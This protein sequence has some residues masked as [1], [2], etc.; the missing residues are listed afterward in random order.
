MKCSAEAKIFCF[1]DAQFLCLLWCTQT[2]QNSKPIH[3]VVLGPR[4]LPWFWL[5]EWLSRDQVS[6]GEQLGGRH[7]SAA[8]AQRSLQY[9][10]LLLTEITDTKN[11]M[12][13]VACTLDIL[14][15]YY[16]ECRT[17]SENDRATVYFCCF[18]SLL[19]FHQSFQSLV[20]YN[21]CDRSWRVGHD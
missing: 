2:Q 20:C 10:A 7:F 12:M 17:G 15:F 8:S 21:S 4:W 5:L 1:Y 11:Q 6:S 18:F 19:V 14:N 9:G 3:S 16:F 13:P